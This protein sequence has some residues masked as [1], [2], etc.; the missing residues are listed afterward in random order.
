M[1]TLRRLGRVGAGSILA[2]SSVGA[3]AELNMQP[4]LWESTITTNMPG[5][6]M[7]PPPVTQRYCI[8]RDDLVPQDPQ[9]ARECKR[10][11]HKIQGNTVTWNAE[12]QHEGMTTV[13]AGRITYAGDTYTGT[14]DMEMRGGPMGTMKM[15]QTMKGR[16]VGDCSK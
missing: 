2:L 9:A 11:E 15:T 10:L 4:G 5:V 8:T 7:V 12:C 16:R 1:K 13:G 6:P 14:M 3:Q